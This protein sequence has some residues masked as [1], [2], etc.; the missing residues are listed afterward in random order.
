M[1]RDLKKHHLVPTEHFKITDRFAELANHKNH[2][3]FSAYCGACDAKVKVFPSAQKHLLEISK[4]L[5]KFLQNGAIFCQI[6]T[7]RR[8]RINHL[9]RGD[10]Y[11]NLENDLV[12]LRALEADEKALDK[13]YRDNFIDGKWP[14]Q[15]STEQANG[16]SNL[17]TSFKTLNSGLN[18]SPLIIYFSRNKTATQYTEASSRWRR[19]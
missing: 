7:Q 14:Y 10:N 4:I 2:Q 5:V 6:C 17:T 13:H 15:S 16:N 19:I 9:H 18:R 3:P 12:E 11:R 8:T 1:K